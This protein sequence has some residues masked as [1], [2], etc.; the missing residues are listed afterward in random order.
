MK[1]SILIPTYNEEENVVPLYEAIVSEMS[2]KLPQYEYE[3]VFIDNHSID[4]TRAK[5]ESLCASDNHVKAI[6]NAKNFGQFNSP[7]Y[8][9]QQTTGDCTILMC[10]DFQDPV[11]MIPRFV[12]EWENGYKIVA[13]IKSSSSENKVMYFL[14]TRYYQ[15][16]KKFS[17]VEQIEH[18]T[19]FGLYDKSFIDVLRKLDDPMPFL[20]GIVAELGF[21]RKDIPYH[22]QKRRAG[23]TKNN[24]YSL[25]DAGMLSITS[26][27][28]IGLRSATF[29]GAIIG[30]I[31]FLIGIIYLILKLIYWDRFAAGTVPVLLGIFFLGA[32]QIF[33]IGFLGEYILSLN[34]R[35][36]KRPLVVEEKRINFTEPKV[37]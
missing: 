11:E 24:W 33:F 34:S 12:A 4:T 17:N 14:R 5:L 28:K 2:T 32:L 26:Y 9:L 10:A 7:Y 29:L 36:M 8:G 6:F 16:V 18:F 15:F 30:C 31:S 13:G 35:M 20:R 27:T 3:I 22:Q 23:K 21:D 1:I 37:K 19:G 25:Y